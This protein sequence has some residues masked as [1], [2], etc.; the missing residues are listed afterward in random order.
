MKCGDRINKAAV[1]E[2][3]LYPPVKNWLEK[4]GYQ[5]FGEVGGCDVAARR[6]DELV[7]IE[8]KLAINLELLLQLARRQ[9]ASESVYAA[10]PAPKAMNGKRW[11]ELIRL[12]KRLEVGLI[13]VFL[14]S[15]AKRVEL[16]FHPIRQERRLSRAKSRAILKE[17]NGRSADLN[18]GGSTRKKIMTAYR[19]QALL[20]ADLLDRIK[21]GSPKDLRAAGACEKAGSI[22]GANHYGWFERVSR[23]QYALTEAGRSALLEYRLI[24][25]RR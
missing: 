16:L 20:T 22:L 9:E 12:L 2:T 6:G 13:V 4:N 19:E 14:E 5:V 7:L 10:V 17:M 23:G 8:L 25:S 18:L 11:R 3:D 1:L 24:V 21:V 15:P